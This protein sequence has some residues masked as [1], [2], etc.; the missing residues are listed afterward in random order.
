MRRSHENAHCLGLRPRFV[1]NETKFRFPHRID[2]AN[3]G[4]LKEMC[5]CRGV[6]WLGF[7][8]FLM[9]NKTTLN[10]D[11]DAVRAMSQI[12]H[13]STNT[14]AR[15]TIFGAVFILGF[16]AW[17]FSRTRPLDVLDARDT[18]ARTARAIQPC[19]SRRRAWAWIAGIATPR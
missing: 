1:Y 9:R 3:A 8:V 17:A 7:A 12:F 5:Y 13:H 11:W 6:F 19:A 14:F 18:G 15:I 2:V 10:A 4:K 16:V